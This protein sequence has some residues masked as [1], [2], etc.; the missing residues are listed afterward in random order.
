METRSANQVNEIRATFQF[1]TTNATS[2]S[3]ILAFAGVLATVGNK[4]I[5]IDNYDIIAEATT[6]GIT[7]DTKED[8]S[9][10]CAVYDYL[11]S[12]EH[13]FGAKEIITLFKQKPW[14]KLI[15]A[16]TAADQLICHSCEFQNERAARLFFR[17][18]QPI[19]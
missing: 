4:L 3:S 1:C 10:L 14:L 18:Y 15:T 2:T 7:L 11:Y 19:R 16:D 8:Y 9:L 13:Y 17:S 12:K 5:L 6:K